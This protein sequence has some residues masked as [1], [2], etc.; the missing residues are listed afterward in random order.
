MLQKIYFVY[1]FT[2]F[3]P[4]WS[5]DESIEWQ[6][7]AKNYLAFI[8]NCLYRRKEGT[9]V[10]IKTKYTKISN[11]FYPQIGNGSAL[12]ESLDNNKKKKVIQMLEDCG[13]LNTDP[14][15]L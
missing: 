3:L 9:D 2:G 8:L 5:I 14:N 10:I 4:S 13:F 1:R 12:A 11:Y 7:E 15:K 6:G